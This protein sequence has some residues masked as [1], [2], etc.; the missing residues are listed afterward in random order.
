MNYCANQSCQKRDWFDEADAF[1]SR[2]GGDLTPCVQCLCGDGEYNPKWPD[3]ACR[4]C[5][6]R[7]TE[8]Y[9]ATCMS[10]QLKGLVSQIAEKFAALP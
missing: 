4:G 7:W 1:C 6:T 3:K 5:G 9:L 8:A 10:V 2:C